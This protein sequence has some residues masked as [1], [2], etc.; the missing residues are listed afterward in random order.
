MHALGLAR[1]IAA[2]VAEHARGRAVKTARVAIGPRAC[3]ERQALAFGR[4]IVTEGS[5]LAGAALG[6]VGAEGDTFTVRE[7]DIRKDA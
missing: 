3:V 2:I 7:F 5:D 6:F 1:C 4:D